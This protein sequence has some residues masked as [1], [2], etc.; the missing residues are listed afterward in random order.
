M[1][2]FMLE[3]MFLRYKIF[4]LLERQGID[5]QFLFFSLCYIEFQN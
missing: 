5:Q 1:A 4:Y 3:E 2:H